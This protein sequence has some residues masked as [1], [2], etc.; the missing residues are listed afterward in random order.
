MQFAFLN[1]NKC[2][3]T[4]DGFGHGIDAKNRI[5][6]HGNRFFAILETKALLINQFA[7]AGDHYRDARQFFFVDNFLEGRVQ[8]RQALPRHADRIGR[9]LGQRRT[10]RQRREQQ[11][12]GND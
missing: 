8:S 4:R 10:P 5:I 3:D 9:C 1:Q 12:N 2:R 7:F 6:G 11:P